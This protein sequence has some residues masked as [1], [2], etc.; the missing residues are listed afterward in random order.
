ME[1]LTGEH[2]VMPLQKWM[3]QLVKFSIIWMNLVYEIKQWYFLHLIM[4]ELIEISVL[5]VIIT[6]LSL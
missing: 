3:T 2:L 1:V 6:I 4:G 5:N